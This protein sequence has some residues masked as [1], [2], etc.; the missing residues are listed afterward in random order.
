MNKNKLTRRQRGLP[1]KVCLLTDYKVCQHGFV[2]TNSAKQKPLFVFFAL[3]SWLCWWT[4][5][6]ARAEVHRPCNVSLARTSI[7]ES[8]QTMTQSLPSQEKR[9]QGEW[10]CGFLTEQ[11]GAMTEQSSDA[12]LRAWIL[13]SFSKQ[14]DGNGNAE[15]KENHL[16]IFQEK[17]LKKGGYIMIL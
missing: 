11:F 2:L 14:E 8:R 1:S 5:A 15:G 4:H 3:F 16:A 12:L 13:I 6:R 9:W 7:C 10:A 17:V